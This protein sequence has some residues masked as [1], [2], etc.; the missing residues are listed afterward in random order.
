LY[1]PLG[2]LLG[3]FRGANA[4]A[5]ESDADIVELGLNG[6]KRLSLLPAKGSSKVLHRKRPR[7]KFLSHDLAD[8]QANNDWVLRKHSKLR[9]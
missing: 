9:S 7:R 5:D 4:D 6:S 1:Y 8:H 3:L 2:K